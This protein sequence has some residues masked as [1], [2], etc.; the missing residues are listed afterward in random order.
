MVLNLNPTQ[1]W[2][3]PLEW[4]IKLV[5]AFFAAWLGQRVNFLL[6]DGS[7][8]CLKMTEFFKKHASPPLL[9]KVTCSLTI[10]TVLEGKGIGVEVYVF[11]Y[12]SLDLDLTC[13]HN[14][15][16]HPLWTSEN[17]TECDASYCTWGVLQPFPQQ[18]MVGFAAVLSPY[19]TPIC[20]VSFPW[21]PLELP[22]LAPFLFLEICAH[23][24]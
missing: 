2:E 15:F 17:F 19:V 1:I 14:L 4:K 24:C 7:P 10:G 16:G 23:V 13:S 3:S 5:E 8:I 11:A 12:T 6:S 9:L 21:S 18:S 22:V 20:R